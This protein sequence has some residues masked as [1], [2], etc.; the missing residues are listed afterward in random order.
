LSDASWGGKGVSDQFFDFK[1][2]D[3]AGTDLV[4]GRNYGMVRAVYLSAIVVAMIGWLGLIAWCA[5]YLI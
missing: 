5:T 4:R 1:I 2:S 3:D